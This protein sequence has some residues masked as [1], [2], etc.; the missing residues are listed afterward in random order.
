MPPWGGGGSG[1]PG[2]PL[3]IEGNVYAYDFPKEAGAVP[4][5]LDLRLG[6]APLRLR[7]P[8]PEDFVRTRCG[9][10]GWDAGR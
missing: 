5:W 3:A 7:P 8:I 6:G 9:P 10:P 1:A 2:T 4:R